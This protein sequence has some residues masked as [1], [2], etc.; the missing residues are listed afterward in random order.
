MA[1]H[2]T[3]S[4]AI[5]EGFSFPHILPKLGIVSLF[6]FFYGRSGGCVLIM[7]NS[8]KL[9]FYCS[10]LPFVYFLWSSVCSNLLSISKNLLFFFLLRYKSS[11]YILDIGPLL[12][13]VI[14]KYFFLVCDVSC[15]LIFLMVS[16]E[17][18][19]F[20]ILIKSSVSCFLLWI[21]HL[22]SYI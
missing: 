21:I 2:F 22:V 1:V 5:Y 7:T 10:Y 12:V 15:L 18:E 9:F 16:F 20:L 13:Y 14:C 6:F 4:P 8:V 11:L 3:V 19:K 17:E